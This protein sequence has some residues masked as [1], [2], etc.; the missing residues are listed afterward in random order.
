MTIEVV[1]ARHTDSILEAARLMCEAGVRH[2]PVLD[3]QQI[4]GIVSMRDL[5]GV[6]VAHGFRVESLSR[7]VRVG[8]DRRREFWSPPPWAG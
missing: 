5:M 7:A 1:T 2:L 3:G 4:T 8:T 6:L